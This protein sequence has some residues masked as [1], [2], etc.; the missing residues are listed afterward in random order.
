MCKN[1]NIDTIICTSWADFRSVMNKGLFYF[2]FKILISEIRPFVCVCLNLTW[3]I[4]GT[5]LR[6]LPGNTT[7]DVQLFNF[8]LST[9]HVC[10]FTEHELH[11]AVSTL[12]QVE[13]EFVHRLKLSC[14]M[15]I[16]MALKL[17]SSESLTSP[18]S[19]IVFNPC[20]LLLHLRESLGIEKFL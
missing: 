14:W 1:F 12:P 6:Q 10:I 9:C 7:L 17:A 11:C 20:K 13:D 3:E 5:K 4:L 16:L 18:I 19:I 15:P 2:A 8:L